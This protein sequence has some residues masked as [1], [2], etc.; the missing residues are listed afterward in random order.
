MRK[1]TQRGLLLAVSIL[2]LVGCEPAPGARVDADLV[3]S[4]MCEHLLD[5]IS[6]GVRATDLTGLTDSLIEGLESDRQL[7]IEANEGEWAAEVEEAI[8]ALQEP[9]EAPLKVS[10]FLDPGVSRGSID[11]ISDALG[12]DPRIESYEFVSPKRAY[13]EFVEQLKDQPGTYEGMPQDALPAS[14]RIEVVDGADIEQL[15]VDL[16][17]LSGVDESRSNL[18]S[19]RIGV[20][21]S[22]L[23]A[24][25]DLSSH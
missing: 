9:S 17:R 14:F 3:K 16:D 7:L 13:E 6:S 25:C 12:D 24:R 22:E 10:T 4:S 23:M 18:F 19:T 5:S 15:I 2:F 20:P 1:L 8:A 11:A 21:L